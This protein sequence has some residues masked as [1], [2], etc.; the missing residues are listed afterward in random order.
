MNLST[1]VSERI[2]FRMDSSISAPHITG[3]LMSL[4]TWWLDHNPPYPAQQMNQMFEDL[5]RP[6]VT[7]RWGLRRLH[8]R[9]GIHPGTGIHVDPGIRRYL[10][11]YFGNRDTPVARA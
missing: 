3:A 5:T 7:Q 6:S 4:L 11:N 9:R 2:L 1:K 10:S 8:F